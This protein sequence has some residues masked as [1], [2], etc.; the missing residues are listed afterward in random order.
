M[1]RG[2]E[3]PFEGRH[4]R[5]ARPLNS[6]NAIQRPHPPILI[7]GGGERKTL[8]LVARYADACNL[9]DFRGGRFEV[10]LEH[11]LRVLRDHCR[12]V[13]RDYDEIEK[14]VTTGVDLREDPRRGVDRLVERL[15]ELAAIGIQHAIAGPMPRWD[16]ESLAALATAVPEVHA[17]PV[18]PQVRAA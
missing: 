17:I 1:W 2:D 18:A 11:K 10:D 9:F 14:T 3:T 16:D 7:G 6:P 12:D 8:R 15:R 13:G 4:Y 5:L